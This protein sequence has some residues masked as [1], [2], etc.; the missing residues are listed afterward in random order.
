MVE[1]P[2][3]W[4]RCVI[5]T[6]FKLARFTKCQLLFNF[7]GKFRH[8]MIKV[9]LIRMKSILWVTISDAIKFAF[10][11]SQFNYIAQGNYYFIETKLFNRS[12]FIK[13]WNKRLLQVC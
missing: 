8:I 4:M 9:A 12:F 5:K 11:I 6:V 10:L 3:K 2:Q 13:H 1:R 7:R